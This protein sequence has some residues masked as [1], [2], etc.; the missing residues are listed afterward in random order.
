MPTDRCAAFL[1]LLFALPLAGCI[2]ADAPL[3]TTDEPGADDILVPE[4]RLWHGHV[5]LS[6]L[7]VLTHVPATEPHVAPIQREG[8]SST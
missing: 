4:V 5:F 2:G 3:A 8:S 6:E 7:G 1:A